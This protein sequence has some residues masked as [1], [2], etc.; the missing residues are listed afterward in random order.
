MMLDPEQSRHRLKSPRA[1]VRVEER[2]PGATRVESA[3]S[4][5]QR[6]DAEPAPEAYRKLLCCR[7]R[8]EPRPSTEC[9][10]PGPGPWG[11]KHPSRA[12]TPE[13]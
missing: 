4:E 7:T 11:M 2:R 12:G 9:D 6:S 13:E 3:A 8:S 1:G 10:T 5:A